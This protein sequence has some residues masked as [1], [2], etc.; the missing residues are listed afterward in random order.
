[1]GPYKEEPHASKGCRKGPCYELVFD[2]GGACST[3]HRIGVY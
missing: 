3:G 2:S 1:M